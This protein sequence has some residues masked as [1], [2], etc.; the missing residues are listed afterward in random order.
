[1]TLIVNEALPKL[2]RSI[3]NGTQAKGNHH[4]IILNASANEL[5]AL[6]IA[7]VEIWRAHLT[8]TLAGCSMGAFKRHIEPAIYDAVEL[9]LESMRKFRPF[10]EKL[11]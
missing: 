7:L 3:A 10:E 6:R 4:D 8:F 2:L 5:E 9:L 11:R 1:M